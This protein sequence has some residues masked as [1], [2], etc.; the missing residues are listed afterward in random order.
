MSTLYVGKFDIIS[1]EFWWDSWC[2]G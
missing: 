1:W 2:P